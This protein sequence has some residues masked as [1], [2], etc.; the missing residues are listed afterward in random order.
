WSRKT[1]AEAYNQIG[2]KDPKWDAKAFEALTLIVRVWDRSAGPGQDRQSYELSG[3]AI[4]AGCDDPLVLYARARMY[5]AVIRKSFAEAIQLHVDAAKAMKEKGA[6]YHEMR[7]CFCF[8]RVAE[9]LAR[10]KKEFSDDDRK[11]IQEWLD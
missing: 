8:A 7:Q 6:R 11:Q 1:T 9:V 2:R 5:D 3:E 4:S 10:Q